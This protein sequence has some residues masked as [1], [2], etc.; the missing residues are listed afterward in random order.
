MGG[1]RRRRTCRYF[2]GARF[3]VGEDDEFL[4][5]PN[6]NKVYSATAVYDAGGNLLECSWSDFF[7]FEYLTENQWD[8]R[9]ERSGN[10][11]RA[12]FDRE[13]LTEKGKEILSNSV[14]TFDAAAMRFTGTFDG[15][16]FTPIKIE[17]IDW[18]NSS[19]P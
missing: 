1:G 13:M 11:A 5:R 14:L 17:Y 18:D 12:F 15:V 6:S 7:Y 16:E 19:M 3:I 9:E 4:K 8:N 10:N 2:Y